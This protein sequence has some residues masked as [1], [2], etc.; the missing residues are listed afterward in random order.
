MCYGYGGGAK[1]PRSSSYFLW[2][3]VWM[4]NWITPTT[5]TATPTVLHACTTGRNVVITWGRDIYDYFYVATPIFRSALDAS[6]CPLCVHY[7][8]WT[9]VL[10][11]N[12][13]SS[14]FVQYGGWFRNLENITSGN[15]KVMELIINHCN[16]CSYYSRNEAKALPVTHNL[17]LV[18]GVIKFSNTCWNTCVHLSGNGI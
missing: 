9:S 12:L 7:S 18:K 5:S 13:F 2:I 8:P 15:K 11:E 6:M 10:S 3:Y 16:K 4:R 1:S 17:H 14:Y